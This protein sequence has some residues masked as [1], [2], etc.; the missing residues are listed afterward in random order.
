MSIVSPDLFTEFCRGKVTA[1]AQLLAL[2][3]ST[4]EDFAI[5]H[6]GGNGWRTFATTATTATARLY[7]PAQLRGRG[8]IVR[9]HDF[10]D[11]TG[12]IVSNNG[13][14]VA[15]TDYQLEPL[16]GPSV[17]GGPYE[18]IC[19]LNSVWSTFGMQATISITAK[20]GFGAAVPD[21]VTNGIMLLG[22][23]YV[24]YRDTSFGWT[25]VAGG[26][27]QAGRNWM[28]I[29]ALSRWRRVEAWGLA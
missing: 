14:I 29:N 21:S 1:D 6:C 15:S 20:W 8:D 9:I 27:A 13:T 2:A 18:Q 22:K 12:L 26:A 24:Q 11:T 17:T 23:D 16:N 10:A 25:G 7:G 19:L 3:L 28:T 4:A 5:N